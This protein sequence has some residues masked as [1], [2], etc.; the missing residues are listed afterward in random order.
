MHLP[1]VPW[2]SRFP[3]LPGNW[4]WM[5]R[6]SRRSEKFL[7]LSFPMFTSHGS[8]NLG[9][10]SQKHPRIEGHASR[11]TFIGPQHLLD[12]FFATKR[13]TW[14][15]NLSIPSDLHV[16]REHVH[17]LPNATG[18]ALCRILSVARVRPLISKS[19]IPSTVDIGGHKRKHG[20]LT[21][22]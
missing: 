5:G 6:Y 9:P 17:H 19:T 14:I 7:L 21:V 15:S 22:T 13:S 18:L 1:V 2:P 10:P 16:S 20:A 4:C 12:D 8:L 3:F 11:P